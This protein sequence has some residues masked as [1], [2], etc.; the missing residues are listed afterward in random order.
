VVT[1]FSLD[2]GLQRLIG[3]LAVEL[4]GSGAV[5]PWLTVHSFRRSI[6][7]VNRVPLGESA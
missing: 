1:V 5:L 3:L 7:D 2:V 6:A 4:S